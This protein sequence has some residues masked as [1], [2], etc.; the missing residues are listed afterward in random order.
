MGLSYVFSDLNELKY[1][2]DLEIVAFRRI[3][4][5]K[6]L[7]FLYRE[8]ESLN[9]GFIC[10]NIEPSLKRSDLIFS[11]FLPRALKGEAAENQSYFRDGVKLILSS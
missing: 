7:Q 3:D 6:S 10:L 1:N 9:L 4:E 11:V 8:R 5:A 2:P